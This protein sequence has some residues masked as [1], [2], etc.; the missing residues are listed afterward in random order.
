MLGLSAGVP[1]GL[2]DEPDTAKYI[3]INRIRGLLQ[4]SWQHNFSE[5]SKAPTGITKFAAETQQHLI[6]NDAA[7]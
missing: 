7:R 5:I 1:L 2:C 3:K 4:K 6:S